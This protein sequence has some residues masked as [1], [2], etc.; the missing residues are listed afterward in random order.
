VEYPWVILDEARRRKRREMRAEADVMVMVVN[1]EC[2]DGGD[3]RRWWWRR[4]LVDV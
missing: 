4:E 2:Y 3:L 1:L